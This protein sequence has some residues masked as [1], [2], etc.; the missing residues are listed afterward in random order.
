MLKGVDCSCPP[1]VIE[2]DISADSA[3]LHCQ[4]EE[5]LSSMLAVD[6]L[7]QAVH[8]LCIRVL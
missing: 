2:P 8:G 3:G 1:V 7:S 4:Q 6:E 5:S